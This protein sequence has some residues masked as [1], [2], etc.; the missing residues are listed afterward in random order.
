MIGEAIHRGHGP[1]P[2]SSFRAL[3]SPLR[4]REEFR[5]VPRRGNSRDPLPPPLPSVDFIHSLS[6]SPLFRPGRAT[7]YA[8]Y[9]RPE[10]TSAAGSPQG[11]GFG[12]RKDDTPDADSSLPHR[13][14]RRRKTEK[15]WRAAQRE[16]VGGRQQTEM[17]SSSA[18][19]MSKKRIPFT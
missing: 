16:H 9:T 8:D 12:S 10:L 19:K 4:S 3:V 5:R 1:C 7:P 11:K 14:R 13:G 17:T 6:G 15:N 18:E 2:A